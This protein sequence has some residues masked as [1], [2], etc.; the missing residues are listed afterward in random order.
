MKLK[1]LSFTDLIAI[2]SAISITITFI[3]QTY[4][5]FRL[6]SLW[7]MS[8]ITPSAYILEVIKVFLILFLL[9]TYI[10]VLKDLYDYLFRKIFSKKKVKLTNKNSLEIRELLLKDRKKY[11][12]YLTIWV[13]VFTGGIVFTLLYLRVLDLSKSYA[14]PLLIGFCVGSVL[15]LIFARNLEK[16]IKLSIWGIVIILVSLL[17]AEFKYNQ[18]DNLETIYVKDHQSE[19]NKAKLLEISSDKA[20]LLK[21]DKKTNMEMEIKIVPIDSI[22][23]IVVKKSPN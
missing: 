9:L 20:I 4:F 12:S 10:L 2:F 23:K 1:E 21:R 7:L 16:S 3:S 15:S 22:E 13:C 11:E 17:N 18:L 19:F 5:Y 8:V 6:D 14:I